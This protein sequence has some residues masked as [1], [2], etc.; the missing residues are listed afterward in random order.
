MLPFSL[1]GVLHHTHTP[2]H[3]ELPWVF[4][5]LSNIEAAILVRNQPFLNAYKP[6]QC[7]PVPLS[8]GQKKKKKQKLK[9]SSNLLIGM[10]CKTCLLRLRHLI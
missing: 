2:L 4:K 5:N 9:A 3:S 10:N 8:L 6:P 1:Q 7:M